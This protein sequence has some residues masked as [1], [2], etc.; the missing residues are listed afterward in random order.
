MGCHSSTSTIQFKRSYGLINI[1]KRHFTLTISWQY[2]FLGVLLWVI[3]DFGTAG[4]FR[5]TYF[6]EYGLTLLLFYLGYPLVFTLLI[7]RLQWNEKRLFIATLVASFIIEVLFT[8]NPLVMSF[9]A[10]LWGIPLAILLYTPLTYF[11]LWFVRKEM[12]KH[13]FLVIGLSIVELIVMGLTTFGN[14]PA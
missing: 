14:A 7:F 6:Q 8:R 11:P 12:G 13:R 4:G 2:F 3:V 9:P 1:V 10:L 5:F